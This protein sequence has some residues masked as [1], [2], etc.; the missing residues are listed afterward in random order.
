LQNPQE[1]IGVAGIALKEFSMVWRTRSVEHV[2][3]PSSKLLMQSLTA[4]ASKVGERIL[5]VDQTDASAFTV[6]S[7]REQLEKQPGTKIYLEVQGE[8]RV[9]DVVLVLEDLL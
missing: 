7:L 3:A 2:M 9:R 5:K 6:A 8:D 1:K 4:P